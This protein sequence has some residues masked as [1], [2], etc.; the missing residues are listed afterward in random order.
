MMMTTG[1]TKKDFAY[2]DAII[3]DKKLEIRIE[4][5]IWGTFWK[6]LLKTYWWIRNRFRD[7]AKKEKQKIYDIRRMGNFLNILLS[8]QFEKG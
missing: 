2:V 4:L 7:G 6:Y 5:E 8:I 3:D 1:M